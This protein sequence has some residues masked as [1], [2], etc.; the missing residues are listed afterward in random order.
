VGDLYGKRRNALDVLRGKK[1]IF[2]QENDA[3]GT[4]VAEDKELLIS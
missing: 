1:C 2:L 3:E 4:I